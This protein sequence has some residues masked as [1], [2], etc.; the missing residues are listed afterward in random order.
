MPPPEKRFHVRFRAAER[1]HLEALPIKSFDI[2]CMGGFREQDDGSYAL[3]AVVPEKVLKK[4]KAPRVEID[5]LADIGEE[6]ARAK[7]LK[8]KNVGRGNRYEGKDWIPRG[9]GKK[10]REGDRS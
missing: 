6:A 2:G 7:P 10:L 4:V 3:E 9:L 5:V 1:N 8:A